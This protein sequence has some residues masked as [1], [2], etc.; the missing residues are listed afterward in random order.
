MAPTRLNYLLFSILV[1]LVSACESPLPGQGAQAGAKNK[2]GY[3][4]PDIPSV[5]IRS[6]RGESY[7]D[8]IPDTLD[9]AEMAALTINCLTES[10]DPEWDYELYW[11]I[12]LYRNPPVMSHDFNDWVQ[13]KFMEGLPLLRVVSGSDQNLQLDRIW[14][15]VALKSVGPDG[16][17]YIPMSRRPWA[18]LGLDPWA[19]EDDEAPVLDMGSKIWKADGSTVNLAEESYSQLTHPFVIGRSTS[20]MIVYYLRDRNPIWIETI[21]QQIDRATQLTIDKGDYAYFPPGNFEPNARFRPN[22][23]MPQNLNETGGRVGH[24]AAQFYKLTGYEPA[25]ELARK[26]ANYVRYHSANF[27][28]KG[29]FLMEPAWR[30]YAGSKNEV[31]GGHFH[32]HTLM[33]L[34]ILEYAQAVNDREQMEFVKNSYEWAKT[35]GSDLVGFFPEWIAPNYP[36][37]EIC[38]VADMIGIALRLTESGVGDYWD[39]VDRW[40]RNQFAESQLTKADCVY[41]MAQKR[42]AKAVAF[43]QTA[44]RAVERNLGAFAGWSTGNDWLTDTIRSPD[45]GIMHCC[46]GNAAR[47]IYW[48]WQRMLDYKDG[49]LRL[50]LL[51]NRASPWADVYSYIPYEGQVDI[52]VTKPCKNVL[53][54]VPQWIKTGSDQVTCTVNDQPRSLTWEGRYVSVGE[55]TKG[56]KVAVEFPI[57]ERT[58]EERIGTVDYTLVLKGNS[59][60]FIDPPGRNC[61][62]YLRDHYRKNQVRW[63]KAKRFVADEILD[64]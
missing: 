11:L 13:L 54:H 46:T 6:P 61:P 39:D 32:N 23:P 58:V 34:A 28:E 62:L 12:G 55:A 33:L 42:P 19:G 7:E 21:K 63:R 1:V 40:V 64:Y 25:R 9:L 30:Q 17:Y 4:R 18:R 35:Q 27:D 51:M 36:T 49:T 2:I 14:T 43:N 20:L 5:E 10:T 41:R 47:A 15:D 29:R 45:W 38:E 22:V 52:K 48:V 44:D 3:I 24:A 53:V 31:L 57:S 60:V 59:V 37:N 26:L 8:L 50:N 56:D 16:L